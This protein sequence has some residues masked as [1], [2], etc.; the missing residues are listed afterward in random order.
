MWAVGGGASGAM[1]ATS[2]TC[3]G[4]GGGGVFYKWPEIDDYGATEPVVVGAGGASQTGSSAVS[5]NDGGASTFGTTATEGFMSAGGGYK[6]TSLLTGS[7]AISTVY[8]DGE[9]RTVNSLTNSGRNPNLLD[10]A[11]TYGGLFGG[12]CEGYGSV[13]A[14]YGTA[15]TSTSTDSDNAQI[16]GGGAGGIAVRAGVRTTGAGGRGQVVVYCIREDV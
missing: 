4:S 14:G 11:L 10:S 12:G 7:K 2:N 3:G 5:G 9:E 16:P 6:G 8:I 13:Y 1:T 15:T